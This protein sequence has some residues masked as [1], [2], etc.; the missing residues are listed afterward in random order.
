M[1]YDKQA[2]GQMDRGADKGDYKADYH[3]YTLYQS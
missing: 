1:T 3:C 2:G